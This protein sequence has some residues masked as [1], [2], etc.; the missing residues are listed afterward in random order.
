MGP[1][2][3]P[4]KYPV[5]LPTAIPGPGEIY[6]FSVRSTCSFVQHPQVNEDLLG[7]IPV[8]ENRGRQGDLGVQRNVGWLG[9]TS[10]VRT[11]SNAILLESH[12]C[13]TEG[14]FS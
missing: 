11:F 5:Q 14:L 12:F 3:F 9:L 8:P 4:I 7:T 2:L 6:L 1:C 10:Y 13:R